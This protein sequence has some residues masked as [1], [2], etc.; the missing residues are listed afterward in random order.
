[1]KKEILEWVICI[2]IAIVLALMF[3][4]FIGTPTVVKHSSMYPTLK[5][6]ERLFLNRTHRITKRNPKVGEIIT[7]E[8]PTREYSKWDANQSNPIAVYDNEPKG[9]F[10]KFMYYCIEKTKIS[11][12]KRVIAVAG[13]HVEI[14]DGNVIVNGKV[15]EESYLQDDVVTESEV[16]YDFI[17]PDGYVFAMGDNRSNSVDCRMLG[18]IPLEKVEGIVVMRFWPLNKVEKF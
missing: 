8:A 10:N 15:K 17:V 4:Y 11:Y 12:I 18:C 13:D 7:F 6:N 16:F 2:I 3:R 5:E 9:L 14:K 1:M